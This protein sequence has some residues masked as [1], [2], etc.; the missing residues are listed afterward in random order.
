[1]R[2]PIETNRGWF[3]KKH[4]DAVELAY[5]HGDRILTDDHSEIIC[6]FGGGWVRDERGPVRSAP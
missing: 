6:N 1:V 5:Y 4:P 3:M 2:N